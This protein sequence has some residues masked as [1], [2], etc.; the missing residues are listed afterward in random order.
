MQNNDVELIGEKPHRKM[1]H[2][3]IFRNGSNQ[4][5]FN[6]SKNSAL[7]NSTVGLI[8]LDVLSNLLVEGCGR[9]KM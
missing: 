6:L 5:I 4:Q 3:I 1:A 9:F 8:F 7:L 2:S